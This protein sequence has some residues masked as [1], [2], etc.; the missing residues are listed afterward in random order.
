MCL[1][2]R[3]Q[4]VGKGAGR[5]RNAQAAAAA[6]DGKALYRIDL[7]PN[8]VANKR[9]DRM[10]DELQRC[11]GVN[12]AHPGASFATCAQSTGLMAGEWATICGRER[13]GS[14]FLAHFLALSARELLS[15]AVSFGMLWG[16]FLRVQSADL[17]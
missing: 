6:D 8:L 5:G 9:I 7:G 12:Q 16:A 4:V 13:R 1:P 3:R 10:M 11:L 17:I 2:P 15:C 14:I